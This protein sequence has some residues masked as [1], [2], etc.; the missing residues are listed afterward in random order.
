M[1]IDWK[2]KE[3]KI[4]LSIP[5]NKKILTFSTKYCNRMNEMKCFF[6]VIINIIMTMGEREREIFRFQQSENQKR[7]FIFFYLK[8][9][10]LPEYD[11]P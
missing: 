2:K 1:V 6:H 3:N 4:Q 8:C 9:S 10:S 7:E 5:R 11:I